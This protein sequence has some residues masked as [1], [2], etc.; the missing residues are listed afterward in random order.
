[1]AYSDPLTRQCATSTL[2]QDRNCLLANTEQVTQL[3][4]LPSRNESWVMIMAAVC[5]CF[6]G[7][8]WLGGDKRLITINYLPLLISPVRGTVSGATEGRWDGATEGRW[9][10]AVGEGVGDRLTFNESQIS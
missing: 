6:N 1:M 8:T 7:R 9:D 3:S 4:P 2:V 5:T 10:G